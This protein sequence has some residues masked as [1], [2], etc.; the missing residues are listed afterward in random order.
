MRSCESKKNRRRNGFRKDL[1][2]KFLKKF[3]N[4]EKKFMTG[5]KNQPD[6]PL[7]FFK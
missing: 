6:G 4:I 3:D 2:P 1:V 5:A 7:C